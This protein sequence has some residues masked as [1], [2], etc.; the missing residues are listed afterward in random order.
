MRNERKIKNE[1]MDPKFNH[2]K[3]ERE[4]ERESKKEK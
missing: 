1:Q 3:N 4:R 2:K